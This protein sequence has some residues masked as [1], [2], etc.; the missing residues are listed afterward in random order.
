MARP[1]SYQ[2]LIVEILEV[3]IDALHK[4]ALGPPA[5]PLTIPELERLET[6]A[7]INK[8]VQTQVPKPK[9]SDAPTDPAE[10]KRL[11]RELQGRMA[12]DIQTDDV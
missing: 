2:Q 6:L 10:S 12:K 1:K 8:I 7:R 11:L 4:K 5:A 3:E 9:D